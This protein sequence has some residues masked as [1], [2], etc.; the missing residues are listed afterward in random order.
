MTGCGGTGAGVTCQRCKNAYQSVFQT[1]RGPSLRT[2]EEVLKG[3]DEVKRVVA[4]SEQ[5]LVCATLG[6]APQPD[7]VELTRSADQLPA[8]YGGGRR[9]ARSSD[10]LEVM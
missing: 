4:R 9:L 5:R 6:L 2:L 8:I 1:A 3:K 7:N 10:V